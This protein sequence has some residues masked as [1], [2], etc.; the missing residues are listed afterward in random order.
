MVGITGFRPHPHAGPII[1]NV[2]FGGRGASGPS[3]LELRSGMNG[4]E[5]FAFAFRR[6]GDEGIGIIL[7]GVLRFGFGFH[8]G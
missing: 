8:F 5:R 1:D 4:H 6:R 3:R 2:Q 7:Y